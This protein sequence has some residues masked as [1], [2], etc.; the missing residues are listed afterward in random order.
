LSPSTARIA[1]LAHAKNLASAHW[2]LA[3]SVR[4]TSW[5]TGMEGRVKREPKNPIESVS[6]T[7]KM[8]PK[9]SR[10]DIPI[11]LLSKIFP[12]FQNDRRYKKV[13]RK[14]SQNFEVKFVKKFKN[15]E[16]NKD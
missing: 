11:S 12:I 1:A 8:S 10:L 9:K 13:N 3:A 14:K 15:F 4:L 7:E 5:A 6:P 16:R 2:R